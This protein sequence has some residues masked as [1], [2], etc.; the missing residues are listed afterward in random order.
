MTAAGALI[1]YPSWA[2]AVLLVATAARL[3]RA[4]GRGLL[5]L[6]SL[7]AMWITLVIL[8]ELPAT[9]GLAEH[10][11][12]FGMLQAGGYVQATL[13]LSAQHGLTARRGQRWIPWLGYGWGAACGG[14][15]A[16]WPR[17][18]YGPGLVGPGPAFWPI[19]GLAA[20][21]AVTVA[22]WM[23]HEARRRHGPA[24]RQMAMLAAG[25]LL[26]ITAGG[27]AMLL[28]VVG[29]VHDLRFTAPASL[30]GAIVIGAAVVGGEVGPARRMIV[31]TFAYAVMAAA[32]TAIGITA[33]I[34]AL[35][36]LA[37]GPALGWTW[38]VVLVAAIPLDAVR[39]WIVDAAGRRLFAAPIGVR[40]LAEQAERHEVRADHAER[41]AELGAL[42]GAVAHEVRNPLGVI[43]AHV[44]LLER[45]GAPAASLEAVR[46]QVRR[47]S[48][49][50]DD[51]LAYGKPRPLALKAIDAR[52]VIDEA[53]AAV[54]AVHPA[55]AV[56]AAVAPGVHATAD[57]AALLDVLVNLIGNAAIAVADRGCVA[58]AA[59]ELAGGALEL[60][61]TDDGPGVPAELAGR[62][63]APFVTGR[64][65]DHAHPGTGL[66]LATARG[67]IER[68]GG[69]LRHEPAPGGG[70]RFVVTL[71]GG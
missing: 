3:G 57:R 10:L 33:L 29:I 50:V 11:V 7:L 64:G 15:G 56:T 23:V 4:T 28:R 39:T 2:I 43:S 25:N 49:F 47:A 1:L 12:P 54:K 36:A 5:V 70:A 63:F 31:Q 14:L 68:H 44:K 62:L 65:R 6:C 61:V 38:F 59:A 34:V 21:G 9:C 46:A 41:L 71:P 42:V 26:A 13:D 16:V 8:I 22:G 20:I 66:G 55:L 30:A 67:L 32:I 60:A 51:L 52:A 24:R 17:G 69:T 58:I 45:A 18:L 53:I 27:G 19:T 37:P 35:P 48:R 40:D